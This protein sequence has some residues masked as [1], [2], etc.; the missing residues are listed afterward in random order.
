MRKYRAWHIFKKK[1]YEV[2]ML[3]FVRRKAA[4]LGDDIND[5]VSFDYLELEQDTGLK[6]VNGKAIYEGDIVTSEDYIADKD[7]W[8]V[9]EY[10]TRGTIN[11]NEYVGY[12]FWDYISN[13]VVVGH[14]HEN[15]WFN[16]GWEI[17]N[18]FKNELHNYKDYETFVAYKVGRYRHVVLRPL[19]NN[20]LKFGDYNLSEDELEYIKTELARLR[21]QLQ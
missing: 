11:G 14:I 18:R 5:W 15:T 20:Y 12:A 21:E 1:H 4:F 16:L 7:S 17:D 10:T 3:D 19:T 9:V 6:D 2:E 13:L 8:Q